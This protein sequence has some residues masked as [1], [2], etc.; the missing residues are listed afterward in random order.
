MVSSYLLAPP[1][2]GAA[3]VWIWVQ[4]LDD[5]P[6]GH[7]HR[8]CN[9]LGYTLAPIPQ[10]LDIHRPSPSPSPFPTRIM[11]SKCKGCTVA[12]TFILPVW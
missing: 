12:H 8:V 11:P 5:A 4:W 2:T 10:R 6:D 1:P 9:Q 7:N 3:L